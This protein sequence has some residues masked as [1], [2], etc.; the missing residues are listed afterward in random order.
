M[1]EMIKYLADPKLG[2][3]ERGETINLRVVAEVD[4]GRF[5]YRVEGYGQLL[6]QKCSVTAGVPVGEESIIPTV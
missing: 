5:R 6:S 2:S 4:A 3:M 1:I